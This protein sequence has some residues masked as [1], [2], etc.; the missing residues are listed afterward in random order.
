MRL[1]TPPPLGPARLAVQTC[2]QIGPI[3]I[4]RFLEYGSEKADHYVLDK[5]DYLR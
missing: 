1:K 2:D 5:S 4:S 3:F